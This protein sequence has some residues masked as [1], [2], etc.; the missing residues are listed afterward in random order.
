MKTDEKYFNVPIQLFSGFMNNSKNCLDDVFDYA[1]YQRSL[2]LTGTQE[3]QFKAACK[4][5]S[6]KAGDSDKSIRNGKRLNY[7]TPSNSPKVGLSLALFWDFYK[8]EKTNFDKVCLLG[9]LAI[10]SI[11][12]NKAYCKIDNKFWLSR[13]DGKAK[14]INDFC[15][16]SETI[17]PYV[18]EYQTVKIKTELRNNWGLTTYSRHTRGFYV[19]FDLTIEQLVF[20]AEKRRKSTIEKQYKLKEN[21]AIKKA[22]QKLYSNTS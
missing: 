6:V 18:K 11:L 8:N 7:S 15:E 14:S 2:S 1:V 9:F 3:E 22:I 16:L 12:Q 17:K 19:S 4:W 10:K 5:F 21:E 20:E 13:M